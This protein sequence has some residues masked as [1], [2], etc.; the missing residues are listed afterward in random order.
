MPVLMKVDSLDD[1]AKAEL[2]ALGVK[3]LSTRGNIAA[4]IIPAG[5]R[6][7]RAV[8][9]HP[10]ILQIEESRTYKN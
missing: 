8:G 1:K 5:R 4:A 2:E 7:L 9:D 6:Q 10:A 3:F